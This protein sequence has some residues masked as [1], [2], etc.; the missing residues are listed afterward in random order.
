MQLLQWLA[1]NSL[2]TT[3]RE[4]GLDGRDFFVDGREPRWDFFT[5]S[6]V[7]DDTAV[8]PYDVTPYEGDSKR[9]ETALAGTAVR[10]RWTGSL[11]SRLFKIIR[12]FAVSGSDFVSNS[13][14][15]STPSAEFP[16][17]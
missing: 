7:G 17:N 10:G 12:E 3:G 1:A 14:A 13:Y 8:I 4:T 6:F 16:V 15:I 2:R 5:R 11:K 9:A